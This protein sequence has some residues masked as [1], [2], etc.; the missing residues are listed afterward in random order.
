MCGDI[1]W[2]ELR[3]DPSDV[4]ED[5]LSSVRKKREPEFWGKLG[6]IVDS[7]EMPLTYKIGIT[8]DPFMRRHS[9]GADFPLMEVV[10]STTS[11]C[12]ALTVERGIFEDLFY[13]SHS[14]EVS[15][16]AIEDDDSLMYLYVGYKVNL[17]SILTG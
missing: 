10:Y 12:N 4:L 15:P 5:I 2:N 9:L 17:A 1:E 6:T 11:R 3:G 16:T 8:L 13:A 7:H 14:N